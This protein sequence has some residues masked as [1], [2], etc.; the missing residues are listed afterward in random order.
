[1]PGRRVA[2]PSTQGGDEA[3]CLVNDPGGGKSPSPETTT[4]LVLLRKTLI[5]PT[6]EQKE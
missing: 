2:G 6:D 3:D 1:M 4:F 5:G